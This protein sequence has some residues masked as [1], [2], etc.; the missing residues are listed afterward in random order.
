MT[1]PE[2]TAG[3][4]PTTAKPPRWLGAKDLLADGVEY[5]SRVVQR[6]QRSVVRR[7]FSAVSALSG[8]PEQSRRAE[9][10]VWFGFA[11]THFNIRFISRLVRRALDGVHGMAPDALSARE[12]G[13]IPIRSDIVG[14]ARW[15]QDAA[16]G[17][18]NGVV[19]DHLAATANPL[20]IRL[21][22]RVGDR[23]LD[24]P[25]GLGAAIGDADR[26]RICVFVHGLA[27]TEWSWAWDA[28]AQQGDPAATYATLLQRDH[29]WL[30][31]YVRYNGGRHISDNGRALTEAL[32]AA[33]GGLQGVE[34]VAIVGHSMGGLV[35]QSAAHYG[36][37]A[38]HTWTERLTDVISLASPHD[39]APLEKFGNLAGTILGAIDTPGTRI[40]ADVIEARS[41]GIKDLR[42]GYVVEDD[43]RGHHP[44]ELLK[45]RRTHACWLDGVRYHRVVATLT[46]DP[47]HLVGQLVG[48]NMVRPASAAA[49]HPL[50]AA[51][52][53][54][55]E[56]VHVGSLSHV[57]LANH[58]DVYVHLKRWLT[59][60]SSSP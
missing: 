15:L 9:E 1:N 38:G 35:A 36:R 28:E 37:Q 42:Y 8:R 18:V 17:T 10:L 32:H 31:V 59:P 40:P 54:G 19:G 47:A 55:G 2:T 3:R 5:G 29:G 30:P 6:S 16:L 25:A 22:L 50:H 20:A 33:L 4:R 24:D 11:A 52:D 46:E 60:A 49:S 44:D 45:D 21:R 53:S 14:S 12:D 34:R 23:L 56:I 41:A 58:P 13:A 48:D 7:V 27:A 43:W 51:A 39:G 57:A 26:R